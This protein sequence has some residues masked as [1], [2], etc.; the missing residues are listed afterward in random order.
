MP[1][2]RHAPARFQPALRPAGSHYLRTF[3]LLSLP[4]RN[5]MLCGQV[6]GGQVI[7]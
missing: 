4:S 7:T 3:A 5:L 6:F 1:G 2:S